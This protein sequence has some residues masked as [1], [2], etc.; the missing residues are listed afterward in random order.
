MARLFGI[1]ITGDPIAVQA[2]LEAGV[3]F[4]ITDLIDRPVRT[5]LATKALDA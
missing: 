4:T 2:G 5:T 1:T 3:P